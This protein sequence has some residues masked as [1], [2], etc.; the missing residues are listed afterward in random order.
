MKRQT[1]TH[2]FVEFIPEQMEEGIVYV[3]IEYATALHRCCC[4]CGS[5]V[6]TNLSPTDWKLIFDGETISLDPSIGNW[7]FPCQSHYFIRQNKVVWAGKW[8]PE[9]IAAGRERDRAR[10]TVYFESADSVGDGGSASGMALTGRRTPWEWVRQLFS[11][12]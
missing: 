3:T 6:V 5:E 2:K 4:G 9:R 7:S 12:S 10:K 1:I 8:T 11:R